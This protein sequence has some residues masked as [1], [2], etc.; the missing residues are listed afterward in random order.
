MS[1]YWHELTDEEIASIPPEKKC[2]ELSKLY[3]QPD[4]CSKPEAIHP[5]GCWSLIG[6]NRTKISKDF[7]K[8]CDSFFSIYESF[9][10]NER[11]TVMKIQKFGQIVITQR[12]DK[13]YIEI[14]DFEVDSGTRQELLL[15]A[16]KYAVRALRMSIPWSRRWFVW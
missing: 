16:L 14:N 9:I 2:L 6:E 5:L 3:K 1:K 4:W 12:N 10:V 11:R 13:P 8:K 7:C 15:F